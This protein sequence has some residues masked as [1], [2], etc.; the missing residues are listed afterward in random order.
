MLRHLWC[1]VHSKPFGLDYINLHHPDKG[2]WES[3]PGVKLPAYMTYLT[4]LTHWGQRWDRVTKEFDD[5][6]C[7]FFWQ[8]SSS[9]QCMYCGL[10]PS[11][12]PRLLQWSLLNCT[13]DIGWTQ[14]ASIYARLWLPKKGSMVKEP[15]MV[16]LRLGT[17]GNTCEMHPSCTHYYPGVEIWSNPAMM[18]M[19]L[20]DW[21]T[22]P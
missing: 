1:E 21:F 14:K 5:N 18:A 20:G 9:R 3:M 8:L 12:Y 19:W 13:V 2:S 17:V 10:E 16:D 15:R 22:Q 6:R 7:F 4:Q 11:I